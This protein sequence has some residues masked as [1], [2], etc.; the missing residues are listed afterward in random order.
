VCVCVCVCMQ[1]AM[2][3]RRVVTRGLPGSTTFVYII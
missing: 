1:H 3:M 2:R